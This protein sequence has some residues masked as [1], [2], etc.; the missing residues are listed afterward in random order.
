MKFYGLAEWIMNF[1][2]YDQI[3]DSH[4]RIIKVMAL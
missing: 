3:F 1:K 4:L 2:T